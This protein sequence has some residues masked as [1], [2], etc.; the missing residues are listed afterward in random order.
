MLL[1][2]AAGG[3]HFVLSAP[4]PAATETRQPATVSQ[5]AEGRVALEADQR[6]IAESKVPGTSIRSLLSIDHRLSYGDFVWRDTGVPHGPVWVRVDLESQLISVFRAGHEI[7]TSVILY[8]ATEKQT[9]T[10]VFPVLAKMRD[11]HSSTYDAPMPYTLRLTG[12][13]VSIHGSDVRWGAATHGCIGVPI[14]FARRLF[15]EAKRGSTVV[16]LNG[17]HT[18]RKA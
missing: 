14:A 5:L 4:A 8:G 9:P 3:W 16:I 7:G 18:S 10:G 13:G 1:G 6:S 11:H 2:V 15:D 17:T 12:D